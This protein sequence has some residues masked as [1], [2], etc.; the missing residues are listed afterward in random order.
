MDIGTDYMSSNSIITDTIKDSKTQPSKKNKFHYN[1]TA[2]NLGQLNTVGLG[3]MSSNSNLQKIGTGNGTN[4]VRSNSIM[5]SASNASTVDA[6][7]RYTEDGQEIIVNTQSGTTTCKCVN[8]DAA[9]GSI[10]EGEDEDRGGGRKSKRRGTKKK[11]S[12]RRRTKRRK[13][14]RSKKSRKSRRSRRR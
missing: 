6:D 10:Y 9:L 8:N 4:L 5:S 14:K 12:K 13:T 3:N 1:L 2:S 11:K 7:S